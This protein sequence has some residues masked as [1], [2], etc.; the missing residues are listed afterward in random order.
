MNRLDEQL[1]YH[2]IFL[3]S[4][5]VKWKKKIGKE[6]GKN[7]EESFSKKIYYWINWNVTANDVIEC[8]ARCFL[9]EDLKC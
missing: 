7:L 8:I 3:S 1:L 5:A 4:I 9:D 6:G 2:L